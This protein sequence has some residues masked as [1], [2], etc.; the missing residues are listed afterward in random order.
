GDIQILGDGTPMVLMRD[1]QPTGGYPR[2]ATIILADLDRFAQLRPG[3]AVAFAS[4]GV[5][6]A[7]HVLRGGGS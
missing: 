1:H 7:H 5:D 2:I 3:S 4:V 6:H